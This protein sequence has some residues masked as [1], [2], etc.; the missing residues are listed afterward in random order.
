MKR[1]RYEKMKKH[2]LS[3]EFIHTNNLIFIRHAI[4]TENHFNNYDKNILI[5]TILIK[6]SNINVKKKVRKRRKYE[7]WKSDGEKK[8]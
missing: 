6:I 7:R 8:R 5:K 2:F 3:K 1:R 4:K